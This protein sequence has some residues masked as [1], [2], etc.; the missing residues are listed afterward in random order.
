MLSYAVKALGI[1]QIQPAVPS[2]SPHRADR[3]QDEESCTLQMG[4]GKVKRRRKKDK[5]KSTAVTFCTKIH[6]N[7]YLLQTTD[8]FS[9]NVAP[10]TI[11]LLKMNSIKHV[12]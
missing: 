6:K 2:T 10:S 9:T 11:N 5:R 4:F 1:F 8:Y 7:Q 12:C 3:L